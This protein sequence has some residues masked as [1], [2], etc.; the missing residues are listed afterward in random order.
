MLIVVP[1]SKSDEPLMQSFVNCFNLFGPYYNDSLLVVG[2]ES[3]GRYIDFVFDNIKNNFQLGHSNVASFS[4]VYDGWPLGPNSYWKQ[5]ILYLE[6]NN[7]TLPWIWMEMDVC[8]L[9]PGW[10]TSLSADYY[11]RNK[12]FY[13]TLGDTNTITLD[14]ELVYLTK[15]LV[16]AGIYPHN[17]SKYS[18]NWKFVDRIKTAFD[19]VCQFEIAPLSYHS[20]LFQHNFRTINY[21]KTDSDLIICDNQTY[22]RG[23]RKFNDDVRDGA[24]VL[25]GC[26]DTSLYDII[27]STYK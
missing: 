11:I 19:V 10:S 18:N 21:R 15:H 27:Y 5:T 9:K 6:K 22:Y 26:K 14:D 7:N 2:R 13:G 8:P 16:G 1:V 12:P 17:I 20:E 3:D 4:N 23:G 25:H 24:V